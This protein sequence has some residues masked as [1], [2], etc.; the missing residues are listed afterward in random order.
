MNSLK[1][2]NINLEERDTDFCVQVMNQLEKDFNRAGYAI[3]FGT[4][5]ET[6]VNIKTKL[7]TLLLNDQN[8]KEQL[9][10]LFYLI[11]IPE[12]YLSEIENQPDYNSTVDLLTTLILKR[13]IQKVLIRNHFSS[14]K[15]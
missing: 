2:S 10:H 3:A 5:S 1:F 13:T 12:S 9:M 8:S 15:E 4:A 6:I 14:T 7:D 11:D